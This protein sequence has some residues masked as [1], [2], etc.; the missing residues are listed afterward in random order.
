MRADAERAV[1][2]IARGSPN[3]PNAL[4]LLAI[5]EL[6]VGEL[7]QA[8]DRLADTVDEGLELHA[9]EIAAVAL[10][11]RAAIA[12]GRGEWVYAEELV[13]HARRLV[14]RSRMEA[15]PTSAFA[16]ALSARVALH[17]GEKPGAD[18]LL[19]QA[20]VLR[21]R[22]TYALPYLAVQ[23]R[24]E[25]ARAYLTLADAAGAETMQREIDTILRRQPD[26]G[27]LAAEAQELRAHLTTVRADVPGASTLTE[28]ELRILPSLATHLTFREV[29][30]RLYV[31]HHTVKSHAMAIYRKLGV[32]SRTEAVER[33]REV[34][35]L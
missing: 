13:D 20:Q 16:Y 14:R 11:E 34:G 3:R 10:A 26:L 17:R 35:L 33:A 15:H 9:P 8:D 32:S 30:A 29:G 28:A 25:L 5:S 31:S 6:L 22:L 23:T 2:T 7:E 19:A 12:L 24:L 1:R 21:A 27:V 18:E 4:L